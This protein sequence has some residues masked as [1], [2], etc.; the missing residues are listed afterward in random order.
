MFQFHQIDFTSS[1]EASSISTDRR[2]Q[3][4]SKTDAPI[5]RSELPTEKEPD[6]QRKSHLPGPEHQEKRSP[7]PS[8]NKH[9]DL[10]GTATAAEHAEN[11]G[12]QMSRAN[13]T[14]SNAI[15]PRARVGGTGNGEVPSASN[16]PGKGET[17]PEQK[18]PPTAAKAGQ[19][20][21]TTKKRDK[22]RVY[23]TRGMTG[24]KGSKMA[25]WVPFVTWETVHGQRQWRKAIR[26]AKHVQQD[27]DGFNVIKKN[28]L[29]SS[30]NEALAQVDEEKVSLGRVNF[31]LDS[32]IKE[33]IKN[34]S[35]KTDNDSRANLDDEL[36]TLERAIEQLRESTPSP[37]LSVFKCLEDLR[38]AVEIYSGKLETSK[39]TQL[40]RYYL[41]LSPRD[42]V[43]TH[44][45]HVSRTLDQYHYSSLPDTRRR[46]ADQ[47]NEHNQNEHNK[48]V[49]F[50]RR[51]LDLVRLKSS[52]SDGKNTG[53]DIAPSPSTGKADM[54]SRDFRMCMVDQLW[55]WIIDDKTIITCFPDRW[56]QNPEVGER[57]ESATGN[58]E[59][60]LIHRISKHVSEDIRPQTRTVYEMAALITS[61]CTDFV[62]QCKV[63][64]DGGTASSPSESFLHVFADSIGVVM[65]KEVQFFE[66]FKRG[67]AARHKNT[68]TNHDSHSSNLELRLEK[69]IA[70]LEE[71]KDIRDELNILRSICT[72]QDVVLKTLSKLATRRKYSKAKGVVANDHI[73]DYYRQRSNI[74]TRIA[75]IEKMQ[76]DIRTAY[77]AMNHLLD[78]KQKDANILEAVEARKQAEATTKQ[79]RTIMVFTIVT[80]IFLPMS[81]LASIYALNV[82]SFPHDQ[83]DNVSYPSEWIF[84]RIFGTTAALAV[85]LIIMAFKINEVLDYF[86]KQ[87]RKRAANN[88]N[89]HN[90]H[91][92]SQGNSKEV[93]QQ[94]Q[95]A[96]KQTNSHGRYFPVDKVFGRRLVAREP[97][98][99]QGLGN[100]GEGVSTEGGKK[101]G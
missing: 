46:D 79:G 71:I 92:N 45:L 15:E 41:G 38:E 14:P 30:I 77:D 61:F 70:L 65:D 67:I 74:E 47:V 66:D 27:S 21:E 26:M 50:F 58:G 59:D 22:D 63:K 80:I 31:L 6:K 87:S 9:G 90:N 76:R 100:G 2:Q 68:Q 18:K 84:S 24:L 19:S 12:S 56:G 99:E 44:H 35:E 16:E 60:R 43:T 53:S 28:V 36:K 29:G 49:N 13:A 91:K 37:S 83:S 20:I 97:D 73:L 32:S 4:V 55:L 98:T 40:L 96:E 51:I 95:A 11:V 54:D 33:V 75:R 8:E 3:A 34:I 69:E 89:N 25:I 42:D 88:H 1:K 5:K 81:F 7:K 48:V 39:E 85:P 94:V 17:N 93:K 72:D 57:V 62:D 64:A 101:S 52:A 78:L 82:Q 10:E 23:D 86:E